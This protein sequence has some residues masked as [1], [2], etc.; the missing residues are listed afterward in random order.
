MLVVE[1]SRSARRAVTRV[2]LFLAAFLVVLVPWLLRNADATGTPLGERN[3]TNH[4]V[5]GT[6]RAL[7]LALGRFLV[8]DGV[9]DGLIELA[10]VALLLAIAGALLWSRPTIADFDEILPVLLVIV[11]LIAFPVIAS[12]GA[13]S[14]VNARIL[15]PT[16]APLVVLVVWI[17]AMCSRHETVGERAVPVMKVVTALGALWLAALLVWGVTL[18]WTHGRDGREFAASSPRF[19]ACAPGGLEF[20]DGR[21]RD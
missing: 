11:G 12:V 21:D 3:S 2:A 1:S 16:F 10:A 14:D 6:A 13:G 8:P 4:G 18:A 15:A 20:R 19:R 5:G 17:L 9:P 7:F